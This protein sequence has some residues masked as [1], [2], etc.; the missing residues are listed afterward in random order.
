MEGS[1]KAV[2]MGMN[3]QWVVWKKALNRAEAEQ[4]CRTS[5]DQN[6]TGK[7][8]RKAKAHV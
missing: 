7:E 1:G 3:S 8:D 4:D 2:V 6:F 5:E